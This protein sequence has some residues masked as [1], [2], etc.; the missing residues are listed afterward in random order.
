MPF[1][2]VR[3]EFAMLLRDT[4]LE[5]RVVR[6]GVLAYHVLGNQQVDTERLSV[7]TLV[8]PVQLDSQLLRIQADRAEDAESPSIRHLGD[9]I[10]AMR[11]GEKGKLD[12]EFSAE[13][14]AH[15]FLTPVYSMKL[16]GVRLSTSPV[17]GILPLPRR[18]PSRETRARFRCSVQ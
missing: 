5:L 17:A 15:H 18:W 16:A 13:P 10:P 14:R 7:D 12:S 8:D 9:D 4:P 3:N 1:K 2:Q 11:K 6:A